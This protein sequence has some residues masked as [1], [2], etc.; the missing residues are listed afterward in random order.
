[1]VEA[2]MVYTLAFFGSPEYQCCYR[3]VNPNRRLRCPES[4]QYDAA[5]PG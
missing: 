1:M 2:E 5:L 3:S 4:R